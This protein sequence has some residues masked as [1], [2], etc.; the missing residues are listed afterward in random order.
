MILNALIMSK[1]DIQLKTST[2]RTTGEVTQRGHVRLLVTN[3]TNL[4]DVSLTP[5][6]VAAGVPEQLKNYISKQ[7]N[8]LVDYRDMAFAGDN[9]QHVS[10]KGF[11]FVGFPEQVN[12]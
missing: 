11:V 6:Q 9:G 4:L 10:I 12:K 5:E 2:N 8:F 1:E 7:S 3:P